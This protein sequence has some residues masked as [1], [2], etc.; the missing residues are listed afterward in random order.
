MSAS[1]TVLA[2]ASWSWQG[3]IALAAGMDTM[4]TGLPA[5]AF[6]VAWLAACAGP[7][8]PSRLRWSS[9][10]QLGMMLA[11]GGAGLLI[12]VLLAQIAGTARLSAEC[13]SFGM[14][15]A[16]VSLVAALPAAM[17]F[18]SENSVAAATA[19]ARATST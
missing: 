14:M 12:G 5:A 19:S 4:L 10:R 13:L 17:R 2:V 18:A 7:I 9:A 1:H 16:M 6:T 15:C 8:V 11:A 3:A